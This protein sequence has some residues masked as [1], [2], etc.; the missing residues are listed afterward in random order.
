MVP[1]WEQRGRRKINLS[2]GTPGATIGQRN[3]YEHVV[4][5]ESELQRVREYIVNNPAR[6]AE[7]EEN[8]KAV[9][10]VGVQLKA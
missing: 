7:D 10:A 9:R 5:D 2:S 4:R 1:R 3:Y 8:P 6:W